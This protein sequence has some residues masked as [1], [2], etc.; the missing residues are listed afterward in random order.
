[1]PVFHQIKDRTFFGLVIFSVL[2]FEIMPDFFSRQIR[3]VSISFSKK[4][5]DFKQVFQMQITTGFKKGRTWY[6]LALS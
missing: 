4:G 1:M 2:F 5:Q 3:V 6:G